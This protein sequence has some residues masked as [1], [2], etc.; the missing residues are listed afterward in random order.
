MN[1]VL[2]VCLTYPRVE[3]P[4]TNPKYAKIQHPTFLDYNS[5]EVILRIKTLAS[6]SMIVLC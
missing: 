3:L 5:H 2:D 6:G 1:V 4:S